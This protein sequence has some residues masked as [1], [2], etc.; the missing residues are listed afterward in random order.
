MSA[1]LIE[2]LLGSL[3]HGGVRKSGPLAQRAELSCNAEMAGA[4]AVIPGDG[5]MIHPDGSAKS[6]GGRRYAEQFCRSMS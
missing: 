6:P 1:Q 5:K 4:G 3:C 2:Q